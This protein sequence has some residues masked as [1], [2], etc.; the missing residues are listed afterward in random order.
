L[1]PAL[2]I[3]TRE[4]R[5]VPV[6]DGARE[7]GV[8]ERTFRRRLLALHAQLGGGVLRSYNQPGTRVRK[9]FYNP[10]KASIAIEHQLKLEDVEEQVGALMLRVEV[11]ERNDTAF[12]QS[13]NSVKAKV[14][15]SK[16]DATT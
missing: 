4:D 6:A 13:L 3:A 9:W 16:N 2:V 5:W 7:H 12:R 1:K 11:C 10:A 8:P 14:K 15:R